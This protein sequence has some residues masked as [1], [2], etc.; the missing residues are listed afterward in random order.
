MKIPFFEGELIR[1]GT[2]V[3]LATLF[4]S[5]IAFFANLI[6]SKILGPESFGVFKTIIYLFAFL[7]MLTDFGI[8]VS[9]TKYIAEFGKESKK[10]KYLISWFLKVKI[11]SYLL[12]TII[13]FLLKDYIA[14][15]F[16]KNISLSYL[17]FAGIFSA[18]LTFFSVFSFIA[19]GFQNFKLFSLSQF[20]NSASSAFIAILLSPLGIF[21]MILGWGLGPLIGNLPIIPFVLKKKIF[22]GYKKIDMKKI[23]LKFSLPIYPIELSATLFT[24]IIPFLSL[25]FSQKLIG[26]Y[27]F[28]FMFYYVT[29]LI[30]NSLSAVLFPKV[31]ELNGLKRYKD[32]KNIL[33][34]SFLYYSLVAITGLV[35]VI[36]FSEWFINLIAKEYL[37]SL[38]IFKIIVSL[39]FIFGYNVIYINYLKGLGRVRRYAFFVLIQNILLIIVSFTLLN[40]ML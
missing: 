18:A 29:T 37:P 8:N 24:A 11:I 16:L 14:L 2:L 21:Y 30:P 15:H 40:A 5:I 27:S 10:V 33:R 23:F 36:L 35:F 28:A 12:L 1:R 19:L 38:L 6:I 34:R 4:A 39:G 20:L 22:S 32:A 17:V 25:F 13:I 26:Y 3:F 7:P 9:L 31:S